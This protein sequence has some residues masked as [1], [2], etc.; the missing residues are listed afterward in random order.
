MAGLT[1]KDLTPEQHQAVCD[2]WTANDPDQI[3][4]EYADNDRYAIK[5]NREQE[6]FYAYI[7]DGGCCGCMDVEIPLPDGQTLLYGFNYGH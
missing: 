5:G 2:W 6:E 3:T 7:Q 4:Y 1:R